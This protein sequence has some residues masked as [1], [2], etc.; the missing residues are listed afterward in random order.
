MIVEGNAVLAEQARRVHGL[1]VAQSLVD[2][3]PVADGSVSVVC[4]LDVIEHLADPL[5]ALATPSGLSGRTAG[6]S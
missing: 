6:W 4:L 1:S 3:L 5:P 2:R